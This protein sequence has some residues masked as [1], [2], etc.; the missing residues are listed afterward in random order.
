MTGSELV[1]QRFPL[2]YKLRRFAFSYRACSF[3]VSCPLFAMGLQHVW[4]LMFSK[5]TFF[6]K[7][8]S[9]L[10]FVVGVP[11]VLGV[12]PTP[13]VDDTATRRR[14]DQQHDGVS[15]MQMTRYVLLATSQVI[16]L[17]TCRP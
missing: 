2:S 15:V 6:F 16:V 3:P 9:L 12:A 10:D 14:S 11:W 5:S 1:V 7:L 4:V 13:P 8:P 17:I